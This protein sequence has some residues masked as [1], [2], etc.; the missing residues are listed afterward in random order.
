M[1]GLEDVAKYLTEV[2]ERLGEE[3]AELEEG[4]R[5]LES[6]RAEYEQLKAR[7][8]G[9]NFA[10]DTVKLDVG[11]RVFRTALATLHRE[12]SVLSAMFSDEGPAAVKDEDGTYFIDR[13]PKHFDTILNYL[14]SGLLIKPDSPADL[15]ELLAEADFYQIRGLL[16]LLR[17]HSF[18]PIG[19]WASGVL[20]WLGCSK[21]RDQVYSNPLSVGAVDVPYIS[22]APLT[23]VRASFVA[24]RAE[25][26]MHGLHL[27]APGWSITVAFKDVRVCPSAY[28]LS[29]VSSCGARLSC[30]LFQAFDGRQWVTLLRHENDLALAAAP[31]ALW[32]LQQ[33]STYYSAFRITGANAGTSSAAATI[34][35][36]QQPPVERVPKVRAPPG[37]DLNAF[38]APYHGNALLH[39]LL[40]AA[41]RCEDIL[42]QCAALLLERVKQG[43]NTALYKIAHDRL[44]HAGISVPFDADWV[45]K[46][47]HEGATRMEQIEA[48]LAAARSSMA[49]DRIYETYVAGARHYY[50][51]GDLANALRWHSKSRDHASTPAQAASTYLSILRIS[52]ELGNF[53]NIVNTV[54]KAEQLKD[55]GDKLFVPRIRCYSGMASLENRNYKMAARKLLEATAAALEDPAEAITVHDVAV[56]GALCALATFE[57]PE[58]RRLVIDS[59]SFREVL[60]KGC[61]AL[62]TAVADFFASRY[63]PCLAAIERL[64]GE[65]LLDP[66]MHDHIAVLCTRIRERALVQY[67]SPY[68]SVD[69]VRMAEAFSTTADDLERELARLIS[70]DLIHARIDSQKRI[71]YARFTDQRNSTYEQALRMGAE[72]QSEAEAT[73]LRLNLMRSD[74]NVR[75][76]VGGGQGAAP[77]DRGLGHHLATALGGLG[78]RPF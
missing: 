55:V 66:Q 4:R 68:A 16:R 74:F 3:V 40:F 49:K 28:C 20:R 23:I 32:S 22:S 42:P 58:L 56:A 5:R 67:F 19:P 15:E 10:S 7:V 61:P 2:Q 47:E 46:L 36:A 54:S 69:L 13:S 65:M 35:Q 50:S 1:S 8:R 26:S 72:F 71:M 48:E 76:Q 34:A 12:H 14:R 53:G 43:T 38:V 31:R 44:T 33:G 57:R 39:R 64:R 59:V 41:E 6:D 73:L 18:P 78:L 27:V 29:T 30:W 63:T 62:A 70:D 60:E 75:P 17:V 11:G 45:A 21:S 51:A 52:F 9:V 25:P 77:S 37:F 24:D